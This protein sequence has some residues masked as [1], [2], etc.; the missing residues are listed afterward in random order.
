LTGRTFGPETTPR[1]TTPSPTFIIDTPGSTLEIF[2]QTSVVPRLEITAKAVWDSAQR[3]RTISS[4][5]REQ[6]TKMIHSALCFGSEKGIEELQ[7]FVYNARRDGGRR[8]KSLKPDFNL[9]AL[10]MVW[11]SG[12]PL[13]YWSHA[14][15]PSLTS[16]PSIGK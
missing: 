6:Q 15:A 5:P 11:I 12:M 9:S 1:P 16:P 10:T 2:R 7:R 8:D 3:D 14:T 4:L 13:A